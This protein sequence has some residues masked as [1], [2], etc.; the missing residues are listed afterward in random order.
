MMFSKG[1]TQFSWPLVSEIHTRLFP[2]RGIDMV[3][4]RFSGSRITL[5]FAPSHPVNTGQW[6]SAN[7]VPDYSGGTAPEFNGIPCEALFGHLRK[8]G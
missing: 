8:D 3:E 7:F 5:L 4:G 1:C 6:Q 2:R